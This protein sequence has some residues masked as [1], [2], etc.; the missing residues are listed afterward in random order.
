MK[1]ARLLGR[2]KLLAQFLG[3]IEG[4][5]QFSEERGQPVEVGGSHTPVEVCKFGTPGFAAP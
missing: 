3:C 4:F 2:S 1:R 5:L